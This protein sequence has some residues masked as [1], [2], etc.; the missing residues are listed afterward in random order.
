V[1]ASLK[2]SLANP[3]A[4]KLVLS[5]TSAVGALWQLVVSSALDRYQRTWLC[6]IVF[7]LLLGRLSLGQPWGRQRQNADLGFGRHPVDAIVRQAQAQ[8]SVV[9]ARQSR[10]LGEATVEYS[11]RYGRQPPS[12]FDEWFKLAQQHEFW[13]VDE[14][15]SLMRSLEPFWGV[16]PSN[17]RTL[18]ENAVGQLPGQLL[19][20]EISNHQVSVSQGTSASWFREAMTDWLP[21]EWAELVPNVL[22]AINELDEPSVCVPHDVL[23]EASRRARSRQKSGRSTWQAA[24]H[25][26]RKSPKFLNIGK[27]D[28]WEAVTISCAVQSFARKPICD[29]T[30]AERPLEF[31]RNL[32]KSKDICEQCELQHLEGFLLEPENLELTHSLAPIW[33]QSKISSFADIIFPSPYY[34]VRSGDYVE[35]EDPDWESKDSQLYWVGAATGGH[36]TDANWRRMQRQRMALMTATGSTEQIQLLHYT[37]HGLWTPY[38]TNMS[39]VPLFSTRIMGVTPQCDP[40]A[41]EAEKAAFGVGNEEIKDP[42]NAAFAHKFVL[43][44]DGNSFSGR[45]YRLLQSKSVVL[46]QTLFEE[47]HDDRLIPRLH[48]V[49]VSTSFNELPELMRFLATTERGEEIAA[50]IAE[51]SRNWARKAL[52]DVDMQLVWLRMLMEYGRIVDPARDSW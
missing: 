3:S 1:S 43:D 24:E 36:A 14:F 5:S 20:Y 11:R 48:F 15:D 52:R 6:T 16:P 49:S 22:L 44:L 47:W 27:Q 32:T 8:F 46:K 33:S 21:K 35:L 42:P 51:E 4:L 50:R 37:K 30:S 2:V 12:H 23:E 10:T 17:L 13:L 28:V 7:I 31:I 25:F 41:C 19:R 39:A 45:Y 29:R 26:P 9:L 38:T 40:A 34:S 18:T